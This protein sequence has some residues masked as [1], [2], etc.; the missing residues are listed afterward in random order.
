M[1]FSP[2]E[3]PAKKGWTEPVLS[4][5][6]GCNSTLPHTPYREDELGQ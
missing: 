2:N 5:Q 4:N 3:L 6:F 1:I